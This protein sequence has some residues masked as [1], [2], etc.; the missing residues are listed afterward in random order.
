MKELLIKGLINLWNKTR[1]NSWY[2]FLLLIS[3]VYVFYYRYE[4]YQLKTLNVRNLV[5]LIWIAL[6]LLPLFSEMEL[7]GIRIK[8]AVESAN[9]EI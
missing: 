3:T 9:K 8:K 4:L 7:L 5:F 1:K 2:C 6:L